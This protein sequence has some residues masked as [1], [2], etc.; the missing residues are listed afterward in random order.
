MTENKLT[1]A[2]IMKALECHKEREID[3][4]CDCPFF[5]I[6]GC[7]Y[8]LS[9]E[10][11]AILNRKNAEIEDLGNRIVKEYQNGYKTAR[12]EAIKE[13]IEREKE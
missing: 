3:N 6:D 8:Q 5:N 11:L 12:A 1:E 2:E 9:E 13:V 4:C 7:A 10:A